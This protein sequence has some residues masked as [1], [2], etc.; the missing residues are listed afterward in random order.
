MRLYSAPAAGLQEQSLSAFA[1]L[2]NR[3]V[4]EPETNKQAHS[5]G[6]TMVV[7]N[8]RISGTVKVPGIL[9]MKKSESLI[10]TTVMASSTSL[11]EKK[12]QKQIYHFLLK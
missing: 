6:K 11:Q 2:Q 5:F 7:F 4:V 9:S 12:S 3:P 1:L 8:D 10:M